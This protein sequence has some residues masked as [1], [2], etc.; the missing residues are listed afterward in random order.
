VSVVASAVFQE[1]A[2]KM[3]AGQR[4]RRIAARALSALVVF[5]LVNA[6]CII[7]S[8]A[9]TRTQTYQPGEPQ[10]GLPGG[11]PGRGYGQSPSGGPSVYCQ[12]WPG[13]SPYPQYPGTGRQTPCGPA[14]Q[15]QQ[16]QQQQSSAAAPASQPQACCAFDVSAAVPGAAPQLNFTLGF[17]KGVNQCLQSGMTNPFT[18]CLMAAAVLAAKFKNA[19]ALAGVVASGRVMALGAMMQNMQQDINSSPDPYQTGIGYGQRFCIWMGVAMSFAPG[20]GSGGS[21]GRPTPNPGGQQPISVTEPTPSYGGSNPRANSCSSTPPPGE[22]NTPVLVNS[23]VDLVNPESWL[24]QI[25]PKTPALPQGCQTNCAYTAA[26][27]DNALAGKG[28]IPA[29]S[30]AIMNTNPA[31]PRGTLTSVLEAG[32]GRRF[33]NP[34]TPQLILGQLAQLGSGGRG[35]LYARPATSN[36]GHFLNIVEYNGNV[37]LL[38]GQLGRAVSWQ[39]LNSW[40]YNI[41]NLMPTYP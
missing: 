2:I 9:Q 15:P 24:S 1:C 3:E 13:R 25:N 37:L 4:L 21:S 6:E 19:A 40:G 34:S 18:L 8:W 33:G 5:S 35:I 41:F 17:E 20:S 22:S 26:A 28:V 31:N 27:V 16:Q 38:D 29:P 10:T 32:Y 11:A 39:E 7:P 36:S 23:P 14:F 30:D 12:N